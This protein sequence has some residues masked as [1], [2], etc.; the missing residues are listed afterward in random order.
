MQT[1]HFSATL[2][3]LLASSALAA[4]PEVE[5]AIKPCVECHGENGVA[6]KPQTPHLNGQ[7][8]SYLQVAMSG[9]QEN[10]RPTAIKNH[11]PKAF[12]DKV[13]AEVAN[14]YAK[15]VATRPKQNIDTQLLPRGLAIY[16]NKCADCH[17]DNG[18]ESE[19]DS[20]L[21]AG[22]NLEYLITQAR[23]F[24]EGRREFAVMMDEGFR[25][26][27]APDLDAVAHFFASQDEINPVA[28][29][30]RKR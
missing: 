4:S 3:L 25:G 21:M 17:P 9:L 13:M 10:K 2:F 1:T 23:H 24:K 5:E 18:R 27:N 12:T 26:V 22:Q 16:N 8:S 11:I 20:P 28:K 7:N 14:H 19:K 29:K 30:R 15:I 6:T